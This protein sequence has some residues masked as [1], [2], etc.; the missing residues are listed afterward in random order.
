MWTAETTFPVF[1]YS[2]QISDIKQ[3]FTEGIH[4]WKQMADMN[5]KKTQLSLLNYYF[6]YSRQPLMKIKGLKNSAE[7]IIYF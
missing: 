4:N 2:P 3:V 1:C 5:K 7:V 6:K